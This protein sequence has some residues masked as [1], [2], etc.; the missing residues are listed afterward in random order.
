MQSQR[1]AIADQVR[2]S[3]TSNTILVVHWDG[4]QLP[5]DGKQKID[6]LPVI[7]IDL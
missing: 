7:V 4:K 6:S 5:D 3:Y 1:M 2:S